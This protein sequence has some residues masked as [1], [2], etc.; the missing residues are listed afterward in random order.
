M[1]KPTKTA[2]A[3]EGQIKLKPF[4]GDLKEAILAGLN[5]SPGGVLGL[6]EKVALENPRFSRRARR[7][8][9]YFATQGVAV[10]PAAS[11]TE[12]GGT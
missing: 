10:A 5:A 11:Q 6:L 12:E 4:T 8:A 9:E 1:T 3:H 7:Y 2:R